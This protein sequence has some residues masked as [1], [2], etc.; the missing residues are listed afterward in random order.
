MAKLSFVVREF[1]T[2]SSQQFPSL[3]ASKFQIP[4]PYIQVV[5]LWDLHVY[6]Y[7]MAASYREISPMC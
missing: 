1:S 4:N 6:T 5:I 3:T 7:D 2:S